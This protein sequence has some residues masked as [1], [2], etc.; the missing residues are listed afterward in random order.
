VVAAHAEKRRRG[1]ASEDEKE[2]RVGVLTR[3]GGRCRAR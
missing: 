1:T 2:D 3:S